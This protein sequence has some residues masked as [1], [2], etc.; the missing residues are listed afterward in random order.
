MKANAT[1]SVMEAFQT[2]IDGDIYLSAKMKAFILRKN[3]APTSTSQSTD[4]LDLTNREVEVLKLIPQ[5]LGTPEISERT[6]LSPK[7]VE[8]HRGN[9]RAKLKLAKGDRLVEVAIRYTREIS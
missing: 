3:L 5:G 7:T 8:V 4:I 9:I 2:V 6:C 1:E